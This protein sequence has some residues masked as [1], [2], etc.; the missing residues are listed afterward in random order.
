MN[1]EKNEIWKTMKKKSSEYK[2]RRIPKKIVLNPA[3]EPEKKN[4]KKYKMTR[5]HTLHPRKQHISIY[6]CESKSIEK[7]IHITSF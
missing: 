1:T 2:K 7:Y 5:V 3:K 4:C 6:I